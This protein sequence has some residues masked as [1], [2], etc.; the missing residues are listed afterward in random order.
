MLPYFALE[1]QT[2]SLVQHWGRVRDSDLYRHD[3][4]N[5][6]QLYKD[7]AGV[8]ILD[9]GLGTVDARG[10]TRYQGEWKPCESSVVQSVEEKS[11]SQPGARDFT[12]FYKEREVQ[13][14][15]Q[16]DFTPLFRV[17]FRRTAR[18]ISENNRLFPSSQIARSD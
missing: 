16:M 18:D 9:L 12:H 1:T 3:M 7:V 6:L 5:A 14:F 13:I 17:N 8:C 4:L 11:S 15:Q 10:S 2:V